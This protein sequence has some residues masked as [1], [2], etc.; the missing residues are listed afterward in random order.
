ML[1]N[2]SQNWINCKM[3]QT[4]NRTFWSVKCVEKLQWLKSDNNTILLIC[5][6]RPAIQVVIYVYLSNIKLLLVNPYKVCVW[7]SRDNTCVP[8]WWIFGYEIRWKLHHSKPQ[9]LN[10]SLICN[11]FSLSANCHRVAARHT[12]QQSTT[13]WTTVRS[14]SDSF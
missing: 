5:D 7:I 3:V 9:V 6:Y 2:I 11:T 14:R 8:Q 10:Q 13:H 4:L 1:L 12:K